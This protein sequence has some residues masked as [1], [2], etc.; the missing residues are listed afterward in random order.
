MVPF[1]PPPV[2]SFQNPNKCP[3]LLK[4]GEERSGEMLFGI[5]LFLLFCRSSTESVKSSFLMPLFD[6]LEYDTLRLTLPLSSSHK[7][8]CV[9]NLPHL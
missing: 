1:R 6:V 9:Q 3:T 7:P 8:L 4:P 2:S 5:M